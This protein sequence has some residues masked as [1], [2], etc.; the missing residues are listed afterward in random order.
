M[1]HENGKNSL[2]AGRDL[3]IEDIIETNER[4]LKGCASWFLRKYPAI[5]A[6]KEDLIGWGT[7]GLINAYKSYDPSKGATLKTWASRNVF[8]YMHNGLKEWHGHSRGFPRRDGAEP[9]E[10]GFD[11]V[12]D[13]FEPSCSEGQSG[14]FARKDLADDIR[15][16]PRRLQRILV[17]RYWRDKT[18]KEI[19]GIENCSREYVRQLEARALNELRLMQKYKNFRRA[20][21]QYQARKDRQKVW[22]Q[23][24]DD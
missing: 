13:G 15:Q 9:S 10:I 23:R 5:T 24:E 20:T 16:L 6:Q 22:D 11:D 7:V 14:Y 2:Q 8:L 17:L 19:A 18:L 4:T 12:Y 3:D 21:R 1:D